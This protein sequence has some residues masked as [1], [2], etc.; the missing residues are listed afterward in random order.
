MSMTCMELESRVSENLF[1]RLAALGMSCNRCSA[2]EGRR[3]RDLGAAYLV[4]NPTMDG[5]NGVP[6]G[7]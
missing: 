1:G 6:C 2:E 3:A 7:C 4:G 5:G